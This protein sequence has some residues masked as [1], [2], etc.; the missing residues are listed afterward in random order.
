MV[1]VLRSWKGHDY[2][3]EAARRV[4]KAYP[5]A[6]FI[7][8][9]TGPREA[10]LKERVKEEALQEYVLMIGHRS[11]VPDLLASLDIYAQPSYANEGIPQSVIQAMATHLPVVSTDLGPLTEIVENNVN[12]LT[13]PVRD[14]EALASAIIKLLED[15]ELRGKLGANGRRKV[16]QSFTIERM[17]DTTESL[18]RELL[19][20]SR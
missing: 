2:F 9:G 11:D 8:A 17:L 6:R 3:I 13:V 18:Y 20:K 10:A 19:G 1:S 16:E 12:G 4:K 5:E 15:K 7:I 14:S